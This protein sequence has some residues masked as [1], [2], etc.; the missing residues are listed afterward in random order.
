MSTETKEIFKAI[1]LNS[2]IG[3]KE[4]A[5]TD[6]GL[7]TLQKNNILWEVER[8]KKAVANQNYKKAITALNLLTHKIWDITARYSESVGF[9]HAANQNQIHS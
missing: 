9:G 4:I 3:I 7:T 2:C 1:I 8:I 5:E 6:K